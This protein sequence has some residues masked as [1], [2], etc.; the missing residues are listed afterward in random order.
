MQNECDTDIGDTESSERLAA[1]PGRSTSLAPVAQNRALTAAWSPPMRRLGLL[2]LAIGVVAI[3]LIWLPVGGGLKPPPALVHTLAPGP[4]IRI[5]AVSGRTAAE[6]EISVRPAVSAR[7]RTLFVSEGDQVAAGALL[8]TLD[9]SRQQLVVRQAQA[10]LD[11]AILTRQEAQ[12]AADR[13]AALGPNIPAASR[14]AADRTLQRAESEVMRLRAALAEARLPLSDFRIRTPIDGTVLTR[15]VDPGDQVDPSRILMRIADLSAIHVDTEVDEAYAAKLRLG[16]SANLQLAG[17][18]DVLTGRI[19]F[20]G[21]EVNPNTGG[22]RVSLD[23]DTPPK[24]PIGLTTIANIYVARAVDALTVPRTALLDGDEGP[25]IFVVREGRAVKQPIT[26]ID[27]PADRVQ[28]TRGL[29]AGDTILLSPGGIR[30]GDH[31][32]P[33]RPEAES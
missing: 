28:V 27:W 22:V 31:V 21:D 6:T 26:I 14:E 24:A 17:R 1:S 33:Q 30:D 11:A 18:D 8:L 7:V 10:T 29:S 16:Q 4:I 20:I 23:F 25:A 2:A 12:K 32:T 5:L 19:S 9:D 13:A 3:A 15:S